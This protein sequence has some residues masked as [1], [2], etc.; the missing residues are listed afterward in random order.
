MSNGCARLGAM[1]ESGLTPSR[2]DTPARY[3]P[4]V[5]T[6]ALSG[7]FDTHVHLQDRSFD[8]D[9][10]V[11]LQR[12]RAAGVDEMVVV[13]EGEASSRRAIELVGTDA[14][15]WA[16]VGL[17]PHHAKRADDGFDGRLMRL[18]E[19]PRVVAIGEIGLDFHYD[20][21]PRDVQALLFRRQLAVAAV[22]ALPVVIHSR[23]ALEETLAVVESW[24][25]ERMREG[26]GVP[27]GVMHCFGYDMAA[28]QRFLDLGFM[29]S[30]PGTVTYPNADAV[31]A[32]AAA[33]PEEMLLIETDA[34]VLAPQGHRGRRNEP[35]YLRETAE[36]VARVRGVD[37]QQLANTTSANARRLF[38]RS[39]SARTEPTTEGA[40]A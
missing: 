2:A 15:L 6:P 23:S 3:H 29:I 38:Q 39:S 26:A 34:P 4:A 27:L 30:I 22:C 12:A 37:I 35:A 1:Q 33:V 36:A 10:D 28:A 32:V 31:R 7:L 25:A 11:V 21:S 40:T 5:M 20:R 19:Q 9:R 8:A 24:S 17:H 14:G 16:T 13:S 18:A